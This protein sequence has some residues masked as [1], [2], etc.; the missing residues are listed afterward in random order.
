[1]ANNFRLKG[2]DCLIRALSLIDKNEWKLIVVGKGTR[3]RYEKTA[4][5][6]G[7]RENI[8]FVGSTDHPETYFGAMDLFV[9]PTFYDPFSNV[10]LEAL[11]SGIPVVTTVYNGA[12]EILSE[13]EEGFIVSDPARPEELAEKIRRLFDDGTREAMSRKARLLAERFSW[14]KNAQEFLEVIKAS[15]TQGER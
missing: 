10:V 3:R 7:I 11:S 12:A 6:L 2:L 8:S 13:G 9:H 5:E 15:R 4:R 14:E 1:V